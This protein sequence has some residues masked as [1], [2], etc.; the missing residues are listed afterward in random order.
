M[1]K[2]HVPVREEIADDI[3]RI[4]HINEQAFGRTGEAQVVNALRDREAI[5]ISLVAIEVGEL[6]GHILFSPVEIRSADCLVSAALGLG[7]LAVLPEFQGCGIGSK[8]VE[9]GLAKCKERRYGAV[10]VLGHSGYYPRFGFRPAAE[11]GLTCQWEVPE[12][13]FMALELVP[14]AL[15]EVAGIVYYL[16]EFEAV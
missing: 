15:D 3:P 12:D 6:V 13:A 8:L 16:P 11:F 7:P 4:T 10:I 2:K 9:T 14:G 5:A 1:L